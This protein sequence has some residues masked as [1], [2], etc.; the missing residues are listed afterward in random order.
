MSQL[1]DYVLADQTGSAF[2]TEL[3]NILSDIRSMNSGATIPAIAAVGE[4]FYD[5]D[6][7]IISVCTDTVG[8]KFEEIIDADD[9][10]WIGTM[11]GNNLTDDTVTEVKLDI[12]NSPTSG[13]FLQFDGTNGMNWKDGGLDGNST[14]LYAVFRR[15]A[16]APGTPVTD[17]GSYN[18]STNTAVVPTGSPASQVWTAS[19]PSGTD[20]LYIST[21]VAS[22]IG[23]GID[24][25]LTWTTPVVFSSIGADGT[26]GNNGTN[27]TN[28]TNGSNGTSANFSLVGTTLTITV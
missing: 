7:A 24:E 4:L 19:I 17:T 21:T 23:T 11:S 15:Q 14:Y 2:R 12:F 1:G 25:N 13:Q 6:T 22:A 26:P 9:Q 20:D 16:T 5:T 28:G 3:N 10:L 18:F 8:P 27:G